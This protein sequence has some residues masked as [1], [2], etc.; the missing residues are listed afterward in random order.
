MPPQLDGGAPA[1]EVWHRIGHQRPELHA[2]VGHAL[3]QAQQAQ[4]PL[5]LSSSSRLHWVPL[6]CGHKAWLRHPLMRF[7]GNNPKL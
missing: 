7:T 4:H 3:Q 1:A 6:A 5:I 2:A